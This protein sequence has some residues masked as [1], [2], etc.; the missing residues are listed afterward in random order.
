MIRHMPQRTDELTR[1]AFIRWGL[2]AGAGLAGA[3]ALPT[4]LNAC[5]SSTPGAPAARARAS[6]SLRG[7][8]QAVGGKLLT[9]GGDEIRLTGVN[10]F[11]LETR[12]FAPHG[13]WARNWEDML[14]QI[15]STGFNAIRLPFS[16][17]LL[18]PSSVPS[19]I[20]FTRNPDLKGL[21]GLELM[22][23]IVDG[24]GRRQLAIVLDRHRPNADAQSELWYTESV[25]EQRWI[26]DWTMLA[27][28][29]RSQAAIVGADLHNEPHG[30]AT[31]G[32]G[33]PRT[34]WRAAAERAGNAVLR[35]NPN[36]L[37]IVEGI[38]AV[39][40]DNYWWGGNLEGARDHPIQLSH[41]HRLVYSAHDY[42]P[43]V[44]A[45]PWFNSPDFP[46]NLADL[47]TRHW[48]WLAADGVAPVLLG[49]FGGRSVAQDPEGTWQ[50]SLVAFLKAQGL[51]Y[52]YWS[53][54]PDSGDTGGI[55][56]DDWTTVNASKLEMLRGYQWA[57][58]GASGSP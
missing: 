37:I 4:M 21:T 51:S 38:Q 29:Y 14:D 16:N 25:S 6:A 34:D 2:A 26:D 28:R 43:E 15:A 23:R 47:W 19:S 49:E 5:Q 55:L 39:A 27:Q 17:Q 8:I 58:L 31:W 44:D 48:A 24:A 36:W 32:D 9:A 22:D 57:R 7:P 10:W 42:G 50:R 56:D 18:E 54:N 45:Q 3:V 1:R 52:A 12:T 30:A 20:D 40:G 41:D 33:N 46:S 13:L 11:G 53:W 35:V